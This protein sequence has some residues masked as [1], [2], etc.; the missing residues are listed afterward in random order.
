MTVWHPEL[1]TWRFGVMNRCPF[2]LGS[3]VVT[4]NRYPTLVT[5][6]L[7]RTLGLLAAAYFDDNLLVDFENTA[8]EAKALLQQ[9]F[10]DL[11]TPPKPSKSYPM[12]WHRAFLGAICD[13]QGVSPDGDGNVYIMQ[14]VPAGDRSPKTSTWPCH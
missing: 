9:V 12:Q 2:G 8:S 5:A 4:F 6:V 1:K 14:K 13:V 11:G 10:T 7:R 3:V